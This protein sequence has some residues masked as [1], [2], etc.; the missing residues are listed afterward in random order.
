LNQTAATKLSQSS[1][2]LRAIIFG[3]VTLAGC[4]ADLLSKQL[5]FQEYYGLALAPGEAHWWLVQGV[6]GIQTSTNQG[7]LFGLG[8]GNSLLFAVLSIGAL[9]GILIWLFIAKAARDWWI[10]ITLG[11]ICGGIM[12]NLYDRLGLWHGQDPAPFEKNAV[13]DWIHFRVQGVPFFDP[14]PNFNIADSLLVC[15][16]ISLFIHMFWIAPQQDKRNVSEAQQ[17]AAADP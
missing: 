5:I 7:A 2:I 8:Q 1:W 4:A 12:G 6:L 17:E 11:V 14:W 10:T 15:G 16:A 9:I 13:R 3:C